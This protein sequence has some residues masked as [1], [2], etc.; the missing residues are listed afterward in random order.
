MRV[1]NDI[2]ILSADNLFVQA[3][4]IE[5]TASKKRYHAQRFDLFLQLLRNMEEDWKVLNRR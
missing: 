5:R 1:F 3:E 2:S 4:N